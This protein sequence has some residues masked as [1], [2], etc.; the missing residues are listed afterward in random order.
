MSIAPQNSRPPV[1]PKPTLLSSSSGSVVGSPTDPTR[2][3]SASIAP[4]ALQPSPELPHTVISRGAVNGSFSDSSQVPHADHLFLPSNQHQLGRASASALATQLTLNAL[5]SEIQRVRGVGPSAT[6]RIGWRAWSD[7]L[8]TARPKDF[9]AHR[10]VRPPLHVPSLAH[11]HSSSAILKYLNILFLLRIIFFKR[12][13]KFISF[14]I[15]A[16]LCFQ[17]CCNYPN[18]WICLIT[19]SATTRSSTRSSM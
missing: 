10:H 1:P 8:G 17:L 15:R 16:E 2:Q 7:L 5:L 18:I 19:R 12:I 11:L 6:T 3:S 13:C 9:H 4:R 14:I